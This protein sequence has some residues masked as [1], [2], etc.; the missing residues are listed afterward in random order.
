MS[1]PG[2]LRFRTQA[3]TITAEQEDIQASG[4]HSILIEAAAG[5]AKTTSLAL[6]ICEVLARGAAPRRMLA[7]TFTPTA[8]LALRRALQL[9][10]GDS[11]M[12]KQVR[13]ETFDAYA[14]SVLQQVERVQGDR[15]VPPVRQLHSAE[16]AR[17]YVW[18]AIEAVANNPLERHAEDLVLPSYGAESY[19]GDFLRRIQSIKGRLALELNPSEQGLDS[20]DYAADELGLDYSLLRVLRAYEHLRLD[21]GYEQANFR[22]PLDATYDLAR[23]LRSD[24]IDSP[25]ELPLGQFDGIFVDEMHDCNEAMFTLLRALLHRPEVYFCG[26]GDR[27]QVIHQHFGADARFMSRA[28]DAELGR[29]LQRL[30]LSLS[31]RYGDKLAGWMAK[32][33]AKPIAAQQLRQTELRM[34]SCDGPAQPTTAAAVVSALQT[35]RSEQRKD[36]VYSDCAVLLR[37]ES[38]SVLLENALHAQGI[39]YQCMGFVSYLRRPEVLFVR[40]VY[41]IASGRL[42]TL[43]GAETRR[44]IPDALFEMTQTPPLKADDPDYQSADAFMREARAAA[45]DSEQVLAKIFNQHILDWAPKPVKQRLQKALAVV[46]QGADFAAFLAALE[47]AK[48]GRD[49]FVEKERRDELGRHMKGL[50]AAS[51]EHRSALDFFQSLQAL[52]EAQAQRVAARAEGKVFS[53]KHKSRPTITLAS[54]AH[55]KGLEFEHVLL[56]FLTQGVFPDAQAEPVGERNLFYVAATRAK[57][58]L[59]LL[60]NAERPSAFVPTALLNKTK[61]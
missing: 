7:L 47:M 13:V 23:L 39:A 19:V 53:H 38:Q 14:A 11:L 27:D 15:A 45:A 51:A 1:L 21:S 30:P 35:W 43:G 44:L 33:A 12:H 17:A 36:D 9:V 10:A 25:E 46:Q 61:P 26:V 6:R 22:M 24:S 58:Q 5:T 59:T 49:V 55:V 4:E 57:G 28:L 56:P 18:S 32:L 50:L 54:A 29:R 37:H 41:A 16:Q 20:P 48:F 40:S 60:V 3:I 34:L 2:A 8:C 31:F 42:D 52:D